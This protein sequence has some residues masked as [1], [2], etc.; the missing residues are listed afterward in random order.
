MRV[1]ELIQQLQEVIDAGVISIN[2]DVVVFGTGDK[3]SI[4]P[5][6]VVVP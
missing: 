1:G 3:Q 6:K 2:D 4:Y 5:Q